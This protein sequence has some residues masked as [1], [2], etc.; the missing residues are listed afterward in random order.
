MVTQ[1]KQARKTQTKQT[2]RANTEGNP[3]PKEHTFKLHHPLPL[4]I[5]LISLL[6]GPLHNNIPRILGIRPNL[7]PST[8]Q[9]TLHAKTPYRGGIKV[10]DPLFFSIEPHAL[11]DVLLAVVAPD[12]EGQL[13]ADDEDSLREFVGAAAQGV[14]P[15]HFVDVGFAIVVGGVVFVEGLHCLGRRG[16]RTEEFGVRGRGLVVRPLDFAVA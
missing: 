8:A 1:N 9:M 7:E 12:V 16:K 3:F 4:R 15:G 10:A 14:G 2:K 11:A 13:E 5:P 6:L